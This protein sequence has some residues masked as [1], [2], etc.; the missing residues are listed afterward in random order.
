MIKVSVLVPIYNVEKYLSQCLDSLCMQT[1]E[2]I[3]VICIN[4]GSTDS[5]SE[6]LESYQKKDSRIKVITKA[7]SG[8]GNSM[9]IGLDNAC[10]EYI[11]IVESDDFIDSDM[12]EK[13][14]DYAKSESNFKDGLD[15][16]KSNCYFYSKNGEIE[17]NEYHNTLEELPVN[18]VIKPLHYPSLFLKMQSIWS[19]LYKRDFLLKNNIRF[20][21]TPGASY[22]DVSFAFQV[23]A[24]AE[25]MK[26][27]PN[28]YLHYR[29]DNVS[30][31]VNSPNKIFCACDEMD[32][33]DSFIDKRGIDVVNLKGIASRLGFRVFK[34]NYENLASAYQYTLYIRMIEYFKE[35]KEKQ[36]IDN[37]LWE[38]EAKEELNHC[39]ENPNK[40]FL[41]TCKAFEDKRIKSNIC[42][43]QEI[44]IQSILDEIKSSKDIMIY[45]AGIIGKDLL[46]YLIKQGI[47][48]NNIKFVVS[49]ALDNP[50][51][52]DEVL[53]IQVD[54][55]PQTK[56][57]DIVVVAVREQLQYEI[58]QEL[59]KRKFTNI[60][61][62]DIEIR[63]RLFDD[64]FE[65]HI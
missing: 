29:I 14:Y 57:N 34:E 53:V 36:Y 42:R 4:D 49:K 9:N 25:T 8:Y 20:N 5:C 31:S 13:L 43:N 27:I 38:L 32:C 45:G 55:I 65:S 35:Y 39:L 3:E 62:V 59:I 2:D 1:L 37:A 6:I 41:E 33:I 47:N 23:Y 46:H 64:K 58:M 61:A 60:V 44:Y 18:K 56:K 17:K 52:I 11:G 50:D 54:D 28:A 19:A 51:K 21:E 30:S 26:L 40:Y 12:M 16:V 22:Q 63:K 15:V 24:C 10:G 7:N 48:K